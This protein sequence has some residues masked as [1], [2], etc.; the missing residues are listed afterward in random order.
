MP[1][2]IGSAGTPERHVCGCCHN[3]HFEKITFKNN[4][5]SLTFLSF[6][7]HSSAVVIRHDVEDARYRT[8][9]ASFHALADFPTEG[10]G[11]LV[12]ARW[13]VTAAHVVQEPL[14]EITLNGVRRTVARVVIHPGYRPL[15]SD[16][17]NAALALRDATKAMRQQLLNDD[18]ALIELI[19][20]VADVVPAAIAHVPAVPGDLVRILGK[21]ATGTGELG[22]RGP[23]RTELRQ[24][25]SQL[26]S[27]DPKWLSYRFRRGSAAHALE[28][29]TGGGDSGGPLLI[30]DKGTWM[31]AGIAAFKYVE[32]DP[33]M[34]KPGLYGELSYSLRLSYYI[35]W[36]TQV[37]GTP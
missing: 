28:G 7:V 14:S 30:Q 12:R 22:Q 6:S 10:H 29:V 21:G 34:Y 16:V 15:T 11:V 2:C 26:H 36:I 20:P 13:V 1:N 3:Y 8:K 4:L 17:I 31:L 24:A 19:D 35:P 32:G 37:T 23:Q 27:A 9:P 25:F 18:I 5:L 33:T